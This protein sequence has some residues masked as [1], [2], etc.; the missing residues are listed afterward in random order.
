MI[1]GE[2]GGVFILSAYAKHSVSPY[3][4]T[5]QSYVHVNADTVETASFSLCRDG[6]FV[7][8]GDVYIFLLR[9]FF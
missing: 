9:I 4:K 2:G 7:Q 8:N 5:S 6:V 3:T 1:W